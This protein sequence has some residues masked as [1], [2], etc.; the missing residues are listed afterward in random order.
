M[1]HFKSP[2]PAFHDVHAKIDLKAASLI[3]TGAAR[4]E[5]VKRLRNPAVL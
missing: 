3:V 4:A 5:T 2:T 1:T